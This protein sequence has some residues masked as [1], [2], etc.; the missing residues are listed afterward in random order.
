MNALL[1]KAFA[2]AARLTE[3]EQEA[4]ASLIPLAAP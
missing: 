1:E 4:I 3:P 2:K